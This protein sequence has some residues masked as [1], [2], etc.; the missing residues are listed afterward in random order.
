MR[1]SSC[2]GHEFFTRF[3]S[4]LKTRR[5]YCLEVSREGGI[6]AF[7]HCS[8][9][10]LF[11]PLSPLP[12]NRTGRR[13]QPA[14]SPLLFLPPFSF[15]RMSSCSGPPPPPPNARFPFLSR[16]TFFA[17]SRA[18]VAVAVRRRGEKNFGLVAKGKSREAENC[19]KRKRREKPFRSLSLFSF[20]SRGP[21]V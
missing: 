9:L 13:R 21:T 18:K 5:F 3:L 1:H 2:E 12:H 17:I 4:A 11:H 15:P 20:F 6:S 10:S 7:G 8:A 14:L 19:Q 16:E